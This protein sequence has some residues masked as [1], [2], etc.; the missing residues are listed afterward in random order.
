MIELQFINKLLEEDNLNT[1]TKNSVD[2]TY[3]VVYNKEYKFIT[4]H[5]SEYHNL[6]N[7]ETM[8]EQ[9]EDFDFVT[10]TE[11]WKYLLSRIKEQNLFNKV[12]PI[13]KKS[14]Q[15]AET[16]S[17]DSVEYFK[18]E[19]HNLLGF[20]KHNNE[21]EDLTKT[22]KNRFDKFKHIQ[23]VEGILGISTGLEELDS[24]THG[25]LGEDL[26]LLLARTNEGKSWLL[27]YF[28][29]Q[30]WKQGKTVLMYSGEMSKGVVGYRFDTLNE[31]FS[32]RGLMR[33]DNVE[34]E[35]YENYAEN[36]GTSEIPFYVFTPRDIAGNLTPKRLKI[37]MDLYKPDIVGLDQIT[38][39]N[40]DSYAR[41]QHKRIT[42]GNIAKDLTI[43]SEEYD[44]PILT[45]MQA[46]RLGKSSTEEDMPPEIEHVAES[47]EVAQHSTRILSFIQIP[48]GI[49]M[50]LRKNR[51]GEKDKSLIYSWDI[52]TG[53]F[54]DS[55][56][57]SQSQEDI[58]VN[59]GEEEYLKGEEVF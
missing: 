10:V 9:F 29:V 46:N 25:W 38:L 4:D 2:E 53:V 13:I 37:L 55:P 57:S 28:L 22:G 34:E 1:I 31:H 33:G 51:F 48:V 36:L 20:L 23:S 58:K 43:I 54:T 6:P 52:D 5:Y 26:V 24:L 41:G 44:I 42:L 47:D 15:L 49:K 12:V 18:S 40:D 56:I 45:P 39:M 7:R 27:Q 3:F 59:M 19:A 21:V 17:Y 30:A 11:T 14:A 35:H 16:N 32:N 50:I 8:I